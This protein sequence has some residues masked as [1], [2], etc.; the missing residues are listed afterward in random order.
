MRAPYIRMR[1]A[2]RAAE[3]STPWPDGIRRVRIVAK[4]HYREPYFCLNQQAFW[5][6]EDR[7]G[8]KVSASL[9]TVPRP[10]PAAWLDVDP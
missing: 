5:F 9:T 2:A 3:R 8:G 4:G 10:C 1:E 6:L 7:P